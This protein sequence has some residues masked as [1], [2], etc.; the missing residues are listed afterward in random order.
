MK[1]VS[2]HAV[3]HRDLLQEYWSETDWSEVQA[4]QVITRMDGVLQLLP[5]AVKQAHARIIRGELTPGSQKILS[6][7]EREVNVIVRGKP[8]SET[9]FGNSLLLVEQEDG[10]IIDWKLHGKAAPDDSHQ[11]R[12]SIERLEATHG[13]G[14]IGKVVGDRQFDSK[15]NRK[16]LEKQKIHNSLCPR[17]LQELKE[18]LR[19]PEFKEAHHR[20]AQT[21]GR[22]AILKNV[23]LCN[24]AKG[25]GLENRERQVGWSILAHNLWL[26]SRLQPA[27]KNTEALPLAA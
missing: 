9:E 19:E 20:R 11:V 2:A 10:L 14:V 8:E 4:A 26:L 24:P 25:K 3:R 5:E 6:L 16:W 22:I 7:Y 13:S 17:S 23:F 12:Q 21:E 27:E 15:S 18:K 1:T